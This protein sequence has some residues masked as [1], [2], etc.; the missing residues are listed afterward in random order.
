MN[1]AEQ[2]ERETERTRAELA[3]TLRELRACMSP[4][5]LI[6]RLADQA[7]HGVGA[8]YARNLK[9]QVVAN[10]LATALIGAG[11]TWL[12]LGSRHPA[13][14]HPTGP[15]AFRSDEAKNMTPAGDDLASEGGIG[16]TAS[17]AV[18]SMKES[19]ASGYDSMTET[20][21]EAGEAI[22]QSARTAGRRSLQAGSNLFEFC[23][24]QPLVLAGLGIAIGALAG[25]LLP[26]SET[27]ER[28]MGDTSAR[29]KRSARDMVSEQV[30]AVKEAGESVLETLKGDG[31]DP[32]D[33]G[34]TTGGDVEMQ[35][36]RTTRPQGGDG[37]ASS[38]NA[39]STR[40]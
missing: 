3:N 30:D 31:A 33:T 9:N 32:S 37:V 8:E 28:L 22:A 12:M 40:P 7:S 26:E 14:I 16:Q 25:A 38:D 36:E 13:S 18:H 24:E 17:S 34:R 20:A 6:D 2:L 29:V 21:G 23:R 15:R 39:W 19:V 35:G 11:V 4:G 27:E 10:P 1:H 5:H